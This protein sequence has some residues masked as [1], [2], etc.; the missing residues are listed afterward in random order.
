MGFTASPVGDRADPSFAILRREH[1]EIMLQKTGSKVGGSRSASKAGGG[2]DAYIRVHHAEGFREEVRTK[3][4]EVG[5]IV[6]TEYGCLEFVV[7]DPDGHVLVIG[8]CS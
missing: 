4:H 8:E 1:A 3:L 6:K 7:T 2:W 5:P